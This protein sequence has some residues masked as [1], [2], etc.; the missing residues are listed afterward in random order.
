MGVGPSLPTHQRPPRLDPRDPSTFSKHRCPPN[1]RDELKT[2]KV[3]CS[4]QVHIPFQGEVD[5]LALPLLEG[6][7][8]RSEES[9]SPPVREPS[10]FNMLQFLRDISPFYMS[11]ASPAGS[12]L[13]VLRSLFI[14][15]EAPEALQGQMSPQ[16]DLWSAGAAKTS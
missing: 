7:T 1:S 15:P 4:W 10:M 11:R 3:Q 8:G 14:S 2:S 16:S 5:H 13:P 9:G 6:D 12:L